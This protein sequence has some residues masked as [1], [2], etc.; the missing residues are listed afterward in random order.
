MI[1]KNW[2][3][4]YLRVHKEEPE[5]VRVLRDTISYSGVNDSLIILDVARGG[6]ARL[7]GRKLPKKVTR[8]I[9]IEAERVALIPC[10]LD[11][12]LKNKSGIGMVCCARDICHES[13]LKELTEVDRQ[14]SQRRDALV[15]LK[16]KFDTIMEKVRAQESLN[17]ILI[18]HQ[19]IEKEFVKAGVS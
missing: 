8:P 17:P 19:E 14:N 5:L 6:L 16:S 4:C 18:A 11:N 1:Q 12:G 10:G 2:V 9:P 7:F 3:P 13:L 15:S